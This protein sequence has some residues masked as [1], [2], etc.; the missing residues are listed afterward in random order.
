MGP[1][2]LYIISSPQPVQAVYRNKAFD[3]DPLKIVF[4][5]KM[6]GFGPNLVH[7]LHHPSTDG[8]IA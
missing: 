4:T 3:F 8:S 5:G 7:L 6:V 2:K 1:T